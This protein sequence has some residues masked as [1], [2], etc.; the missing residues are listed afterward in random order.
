MAI[1]PLQFPKDWPR[2][3]KPHFLLGLP[4]VGAQERVYRDLCA[5]LAPR[6]EECWDQWGTTG[7]RIDL[8]RFIARAFGEAADWPNPIFVPDDPFVLVTWDHDAC[9]LDDM[10][11]DDALQDIARHAGVKGINWRRFDACTLG[12]VV[13]QLLHEGLPSGA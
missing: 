4:I 11:G 3:V 5:Q 10:A 12:Q 13:D 9:G 1:P 2:I 8:A 6:T 7:P